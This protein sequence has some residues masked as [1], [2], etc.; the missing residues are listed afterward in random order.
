M[1]KISIFILL[2]ATITLSGC[3]L[4]EPSNPERLSKSINYS[5]QA[6]VILNQTGSN[7]SQENMTEI[8]KLKKQALDEALLVDTK[9]LN[10]Q[11]QGFGDQWKSKYIKGLELFIEGIENG[12]NQKS[13]QGQVLL[14]QWGEW[15]SSNIDEIRSN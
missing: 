13:L 14:D 7:L 4:S 12:D 9:A 5:N 11:Y 6:A 1:F 8:I 15:Y 10:N 3:S 2:F